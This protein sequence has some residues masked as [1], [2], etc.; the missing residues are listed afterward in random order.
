MAAEYLDID[1]NFQHEVIAEMLRRE[2][3]IRDR[4][5]PFVMYDDLDF[6]DRFRLSKAGVI[7]LMR[8]VGNHLDEGRRGIDIPPMMQLLVTLRYFATGSYLR[9]VGDSFGMHITTVSNIVKKVSRNIASQRAMY[10]HYPDE[11]QRLNTQQQFFRLCRI[12]GIIGAIDCTHIP[13]I[14]PGGQNAEIFRN[15]KGFFSVN[16]QGGLLLILACCKNSSVS[17]FYL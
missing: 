12:P 7:E 17:E 13:I 2:R 16:V 3:M 1:L 14:S 4:A 11:R 6:L 9:L 10:I 8:I 5:N 15:R